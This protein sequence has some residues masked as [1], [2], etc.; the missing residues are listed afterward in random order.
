MRS[1]QSTQIDRS[2]VAHTPTRVDHGVPDK[3]HMHNV[4][5]LL[6]ILITT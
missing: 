3:A 1:M 2:T 5:D 4:H 6:S